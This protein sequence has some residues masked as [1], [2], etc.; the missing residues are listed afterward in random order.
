MYALGFPPEPRRHSEPKR[1]PASIVVRDI[2]PSLVCGISQL[3]R[4]G[5]SEAETPA[6]HKDFFIGPFR[7][8]SALTCQGAR[9]LKRIRRLESVF[10]SRAV[11]WDL[12]DMLTFAPMKCI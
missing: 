7:T 4:E 3:Y 1:G 10:S 12:L 11:P 9:G 2:L 5:E 8:T 6:C